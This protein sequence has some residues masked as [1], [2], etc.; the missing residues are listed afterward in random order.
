MHSDE[1]AHV[2]YDT[3]DPSMVLHTVHAIQADVPHTANL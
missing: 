2:V 1:H 3:G